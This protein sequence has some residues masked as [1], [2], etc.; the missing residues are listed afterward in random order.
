MF[1]FVIA[2]IDQW[3]GDKSLAQMVICLQ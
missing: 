1:E 3:T 2:I